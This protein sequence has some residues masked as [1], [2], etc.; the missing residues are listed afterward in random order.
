MVNIDM[1]NIDMLNIGMVNLDMV[2]IGMV[3]TIF[4]VPLFKTYHYIFLIY[5]SLESQKLY[6]PSKPIV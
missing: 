5:L 4:R 3:S 2:N 1:V 6:Y